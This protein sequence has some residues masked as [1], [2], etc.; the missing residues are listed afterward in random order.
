MSVDQC[1]TKCDALFDLMAGNDEQKADKWCHFECACQKNNT[2]TFD[3]KTSTAAP[4]RTTMMIWTN[5]PTTAATNPSSTV[6]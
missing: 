5:M 2:C 1:T 4:S 3:M 6:P